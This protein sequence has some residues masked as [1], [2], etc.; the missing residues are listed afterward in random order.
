MIEAIK[1]F[2]QPLWRKRFWVGSLSAVLIVPIVS[3]IFLLSVIGFAPLPMIYFMFITG[4]IGALLEFA[5][6][7]FI[8]LV[9]EKIN[10]RS[11]NSY[12]YAAVAVIA[13]YSIAVFFI[14]WPGLWEKTLN[15][16]GLHWLLN[17]LSAYI[18]WR[19]AVKPLENK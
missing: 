3:T 13:C 11:K 18:F 5:P 12:L 17:S 6:L 16:F 19:I 2:I 8:H 15:Y 14:Y 10:I 4:L 9:F 7:I 1:D